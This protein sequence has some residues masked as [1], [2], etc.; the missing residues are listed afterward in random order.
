MHNVLVFA[1][2]V[3]ATPKPG[4]IDKPL[5]QLLNML[6]ATGLIAAA[7]GFVTGGVMSVVGGS[8]GNYGIAA[9][10][11]AMM[12][13]AGLGPALIAGATAIVNWFWGLGL[14]I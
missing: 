11:K 7:I 8:G 3:S 2:S 9:R 10:G 13:W 5:Q 14:L 4:P 6:V 12:G 1:F